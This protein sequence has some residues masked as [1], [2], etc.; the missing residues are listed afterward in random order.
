MSIFK[1]RSAARPV[2]SA[3]K[4]PNG[5]PEPTPTTP[6]AIPDELIAARAYEKWQRRGCPVGQDGERDWFA[7][8]SEL[9]QERLGWAAPTEDDRS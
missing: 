7:A 8:R 6:D 1:K 4:P 2:K 3:P 9:E 5:V